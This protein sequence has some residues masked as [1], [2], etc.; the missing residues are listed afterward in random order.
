MMLEMRF[1]RGVIVA[2]TGAIV[3]IVVT[4]QPAAAHGVGGVEPSN[5]ETTVHGT[6]PRVSGLTVR[7]IDLGNELEVRNDTGADVV[8]LGYQGEAYLRVGS[9]RVFENR[10]SPATY[11]NRTRDGKTQVPV[12]RRSRCGTRVGADRLGK[13]GAMAR[14]PGA[15]DGQ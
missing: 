15:L 13:C 1:V 8:V 3:A 12:L 10:R 7:T 6:T 5:F 14:P 11:L 4:A 2:A 9:A